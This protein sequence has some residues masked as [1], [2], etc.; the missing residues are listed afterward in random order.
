MKKENSKREAIELINKAYNLVEGGKFE[1]AKRLLKRA[2]DICDEIADGHNEL[3]VVYCLLGDFPSA[4]HHALR[5][6]ELAPT[7][8]KYHNSLAFTL[9]SMGRLDNALV[10]ARTAIGLNPNYASAQNLVSKIL[11]M[12]GEPE[13]ASY[14]EWKAQKIYESTKMRS[15]G[16]ELKAGD[17]KRFFSG[18]ETI[19][20]KPESIESIN[21]KGIKWALSQIKKNPD[22]AKSKTVREAIMN[23]I[24]RWS[25]VII[26]P[27][28]GFL[29][30]IKPGQISYK[31]GNFDR[32]W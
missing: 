24:A 22:A 32:I 2:L 10:S 15:D 21:V 5:A 13:E 27:I 6:I 14:H 8:P 12:K 18:R 3:G 31:S 9:M 7:N 16:H 4:Y 1:E 11:K 19:I 23:P 20:K 30:F 29:G 28:A 17:L 26:M 25:F